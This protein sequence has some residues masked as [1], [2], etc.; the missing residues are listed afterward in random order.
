MDMYDEVI[1]PDGGTAHVKCWGCY[2]SLFSE[3][4]H[5]PKIEDH[6][7]YTVYLSDNSLFVHV[8]QRRIYKISELP[9][10]RP[11]FDTR[12]NDLVDSEIPG[13]LPP[14]IPKPPTDIAELK[15]HVESLSGAVH[16]IECLLGIEP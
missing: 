7:T 11:F 2:L 12:G 1:L 3:G 9:V 4:S 14:P 16:R 15:L 13:P 10:Q 5:V 8:V 6:D